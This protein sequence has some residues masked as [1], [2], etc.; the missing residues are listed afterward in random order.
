MPWCHDEIC[1]NASVAHV[2]IWYV[3]SGTHLP[4]LYNNHRPT[5]CL[6]LSCPY[7]FIL[8][9]YVSFLTFILINFDVR[10]FFKRF[11]AFMEIFY[12]NFEHKYFLLLSFNGTVNCINFLLFDNMAKYL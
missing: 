2:E 1:L 10:A 5:P 3:P 12:L 7:L 4:S 6:T 9:L 11:L 8:R